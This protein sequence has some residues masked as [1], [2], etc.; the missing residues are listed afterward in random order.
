MAT[1]TSPNKRF[2]EQ[3]NS[4]AHAFSILVHFFV[5]LCKTTMW[6]DQILHGLEDVNHDSAAYFFVSSD[7]SSLNLLHNC[8]YC[9]AKDKF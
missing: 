9:L 5:A 1:R 7:L 2:N 6:N 4:S 3:Y 8:T